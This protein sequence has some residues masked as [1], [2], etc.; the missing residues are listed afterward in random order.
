MRA[1]L[2]WQ[3]AQTLLPTKCAPSIRGGSTTLRSS[4]EQE[5]TNKAVAPASASAAVKAYVRQAFIGEQ[6]CD[7]GRRSPLFVAATFDES[8]R[9]FQASIAFGNQLVRESSHLE[10]ICMWRS[11]A[12]KRNG[13]TEAHRIAQRVDATKLTPSPPSD[14]GEGRGEE[15]H[16]VRMPRSS[17]LS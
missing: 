12:R 14:G 16:C 15:G 2:L 8:R 5:L 11:S 6:I 7:S 17:V 10:A 9:A 1:M 4:E 13:I 3:S